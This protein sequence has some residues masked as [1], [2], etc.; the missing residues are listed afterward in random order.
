MSVRI[1][2]WGCGAWGANVLRDLRALDARVTVLARSE[3]TAARAREGGAQVVTNLA[4][5][6]MTPTAWTGS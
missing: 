3:E 4:D 2:Q 6:D 5:I 1:L